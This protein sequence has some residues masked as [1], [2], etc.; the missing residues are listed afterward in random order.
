IDLF[1]VQLDLEVLDELL[2]IADFLLPFQK[3]PEPDEV[4]IVALIADSSFLVLPV[5]CDA[6][7]GHPMHFY[8][9]DLDLERHAVFADDRGVQRLIAV[10]TRHRD[11]VLDAAG[12]RRPG[13]MD[14]AERRVAVLDAF[15]HH[16]NG[17]EVVHLLEL[18]L[19]ALQLLT[20]APE[21]FDAAVDLGDRYLRFSQLRRERLLEL[22]D[23]AFS[24][25]PSPV[26]LRAQSLVFDRLEVSKRQL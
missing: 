19:L 20:D 1:G 25:A 14:D 8:R 21:A 13:L 18:D 24:R 26:D 7:L 23:H 16:T 9:P 17:D 2:G 3:L 10:R 12:D 11:E 4:A 22:L 5:C 6:F 15:G